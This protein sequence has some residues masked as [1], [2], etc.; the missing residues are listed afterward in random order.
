MLAEPGE[1]PSGDMV[2]DNRGGLQRQVLFFM[3]GGGRNRES[4]TNK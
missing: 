3:G 4:L 1:E 2:I